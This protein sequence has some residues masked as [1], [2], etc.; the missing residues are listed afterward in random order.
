MKKIILKGNAHWFEAFSK[1]IT[2]FKAL[3]KWYKDTKID[4]PIK[5]AMFNTRNDG[6]LKKCVPFLDAM[7]AG[8]V[9]TAAQDFGIKL[10][11]DKEG[12]H[13]WHSE[14]PA[15]TLPQIISS[16]TS[17]Q[18]GP[19][20]KPFKDFVTLKY[21]NP[22]VL[23]TPPGYSLLY[24][25]LLNNFELQNKGIHFLSGIVDA[26]RFPIAVALPFICTNFDDEILVEKG[27]PL[28]QAIPI[29]KENWVMSEAIMDS[30][31]YES[32]YNKLTTKFRDAY[33]NMFWNQSKYR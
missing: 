24:T 19:Y 17:P 18:L 21:D 31:E 14:S 12:K 28:V 1:P 26:D 4:G 13:N 27:T 25:P 8:Y 30:N 2:A 9:I 7:T 32:N 11:Y 3:P 23:N 29:K 22:Y 10:Y 15:P 5:Q 16:H 33:K 6:T 20:W